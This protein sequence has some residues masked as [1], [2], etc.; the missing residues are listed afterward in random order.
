MNLCIVQVL[1]TAFSWKDGQAARAVRL[2]PFIDAT[3]AE[4]EVYLQREQVPSPHD[5]MKQL[6]TGETVEDSLTGECVI[7]YPVFVVQLPCRNT[8]DVTAKPA[9]HQPLLQLEANRVLA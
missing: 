8:P 9:H 5:R 1:N 4:C 3:P 2:S 6:S 7:E